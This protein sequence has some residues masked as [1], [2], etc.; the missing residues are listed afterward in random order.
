MK[1]LVLGLTLMLSAVAQAV[2]IKILDIPEWPGSTVNSKFEFNK[3]LGRAWVEI[4]V[5]RG[6]GEDSSSDFYRTKVEG[7]FFDILTSSVVIEHQ[8]LLIECAQVSMRGRSIF[9]I[10]RI[11][12]TNCEFTSKVVT[13]LVDD[14]FEIK[15]RYRLQ[16][17]LVTK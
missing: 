2:E 9:R 16:V 8:G 3:E 12:N 5:S 17:F 4:E 1:I 10:E 15:K 11:K 14:G 6:S 13:V 7:L